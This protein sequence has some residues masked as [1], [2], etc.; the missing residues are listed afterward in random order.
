MVYFVLFCSVQFSVFFYESSVL[1]CSFLFALTVHFVLF[2]LLNIPFGAAHFCSVLL[3]S[4]L[5]CS[6]VTFCSFRFC[7]SVD[8]VCYIPFY[9]PYLNL[10]FL[11]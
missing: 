1:F 9:S 5:S 8:L 10:G 7:S 2:Y 3:N 6:K 11:F 4:V